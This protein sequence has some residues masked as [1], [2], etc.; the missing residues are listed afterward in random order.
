MLTKGA[1]ED[2]VMAHLSRKVPGAAAAAPHGR[3]VPEL[4]KRVFLTDRELRSMCRP[5]DRTVTVPANAILSPLAL[6]WLDFDG[7]RVI[8]I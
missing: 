7:I 1:L 4:K 8:R 6:D 3:K 5:G 2:I